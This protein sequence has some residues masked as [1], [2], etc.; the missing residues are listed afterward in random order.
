MRGR[1]RG[2]CYHWWWSRRRMND[3]GRRGI[4]RSRNV[5]SRSRSRDRGRGRT[6]RMVRRGG[7]DQPCWRWFVIIVVIYFVS[8]AVG[9]L[10]VRIIIR[11]SRSWIPSRR[12]LLGL[13]LA[14]W[15]RLPVPLGLAIW[16]RLLP[17]ALGLAVC[18]GL[19]I[20]WRLSVRGCL[21]V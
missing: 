21:S 10:G 4:A 3:S 1:H 16:G 15:R 6:G 13:I 17:I 5:G 18:R 11:G 7:L 9:A 2:L 19:A 8:W 12:I 20:T 14:I